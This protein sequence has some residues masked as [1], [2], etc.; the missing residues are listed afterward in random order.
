MS[1]CMLE[2]RVRGEKATGHL[3]DSS[4]ASYE[5]CPGGRTVLVLPTMAVV[6]CQ[7]LTHPR[8]GKGGDFCESRPCRGSGKEGAEV[9]PGILTANLLSRHSL[10]N[11]TDSRYLCLVVSSGAK[12]THKRMKDRRSVCLLSC[13]CIITLLTQP[14]PPQP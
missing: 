11:E 7:P 1:A 9:L 4:D 8:V 3:S 10:D 5:G 6:L 13:T 14:P 12:C 2:G